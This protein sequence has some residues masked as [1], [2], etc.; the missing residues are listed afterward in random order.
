MALIV[1]DFGRFYVGW[2]ADCVAASLNASLILW[3][4]IMS[5]Q[6]KRLENLIP[7]ANLEW[8]TSF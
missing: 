1:G 3:I 6:M 4:A 7:S 2:V 8:V 5:G